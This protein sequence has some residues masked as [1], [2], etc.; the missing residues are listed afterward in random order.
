MKKLV[1]CKKCGSQPIIEKFVKE[2]ICKC[3]KCGFRT[4]M[5]QV[6]FRTKKLAIE[7]WETMEARNESDT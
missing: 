3:P 5:G 4:S 1:S 2:W 7:N 6:V